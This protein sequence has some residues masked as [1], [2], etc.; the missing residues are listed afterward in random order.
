LWVEN[1][2]DADNVV[3]V[4]RS[5]GDPYTTGYLSTPEGQAIARERGQK[6]VDDYM[7]LE[8]DPVN[9]GIPR[10][11]KLGFRINFSGFGF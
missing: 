9:F 3:N 2:F 6:Y 8:R 10:L 11:I 4:Y 7:S 1:V 5:T